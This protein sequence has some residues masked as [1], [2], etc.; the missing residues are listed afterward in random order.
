MDPLHLRPDEL[1]Y[2]L[3]IRGVHNLGSQRQKSSVLR[4][5]LEKERLGTEKAPEDSSNLFPAEI[6]IKNCTSLYSNIIDIAEAEGTSAITLNECVSRL[7]HLGGRINRIK[8]TTEVDEL[9]V[10]DLGLCA[11]ESLKKIVIR[12]EAGIVRPEQGVPPTIPVATTNDAE[13]D[14]L[15]S[16][17]G[18]AGLS[19]GG[20][21][22]SNLINFQQNAANSFSQDLLSQQT[23]PSQQ[24]FAR[25]PEAFRTTC[26]PMPDLS[27][28]FNRSSAPPVQQQPPTGG[29]R[30]ANAPNLR[31]NSGQSIRQNE[32]FGFSR[33]QLRPTYFVPPFQGYQQNQ[34]EAFQQPLN[35]VGPEQRQFFDEWQFPP[36]Q[37][38]RPDR[39]RKTVPVYQWRVSFS[40]DSKGVHLYDF[41]SKISMYKRSE[42][43]TDEDLLLSIGHLLTGK[44]LQWYV[45]EGDMYHSLPALV[46]AMRR[47]FLP[48]DYDYRLQLEISNRQQKTSESFAEYMTHMKSLFKCLSV[49]M[50]EAQQVCILK[51]NLLQKYAIGVANAP[52][53]SLARL[54]EICERLDDVF[55]RD[56]NL[57]MP[58]QE[59]V[60]KFS[61]PFNR[62]YGNYRE[63]NVID[64]DCDSKSDSAE[65][66]ELCAMH[67]SRRSN[68]NKFIRPRSS[69]NDAVKSSSSIECWNCK[70]NGHVFNDCS[71]PQLNRFCFKCG[72]PDV[73]VNNCSKCKGNANQNSGAQGPVASSP[74]QGS[75]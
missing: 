67:A 1:S 63:A 22:Q 2:E 62:S 23:R 37:N 15:A 64:V 61:R 69:N 11:S 57:T 52:D 59:T 60:S 26:P 40:G 38:Q 36:V 3:L 51:K 66:Q 56:S 7:R 4:T 34:Y 70:Q 12:L 42:Q 50:T 54:C 28:M 53:G 39:F 32:T 49:P 10:N 46:D 73:I 71:K 29:S 5:L 16:D 75:Q 58:F 74:Q 44:A 27:S 31:S 55:N 13:V 48:P 72:N 30:N 17:L 35:R 24:I 25:T 41:L 20:D 19:T 33:P 18:A 21:N 47:R 8:T 68:T 9:N 43:I 6:E 14:H 65:E 45:A